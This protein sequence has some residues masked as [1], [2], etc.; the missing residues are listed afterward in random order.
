LLEAS[1]LHVASECS[2]RATRPERAGEAAS[3]GA[4]RGVRAAKPL[5]KK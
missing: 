2:E 4:C 5:G 1:D 3:E